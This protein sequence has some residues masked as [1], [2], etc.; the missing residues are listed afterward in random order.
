MYN[1]MGKSKIHRCHICGK[2][3]SQGSHLKRHMEIHD[4]IMRECRYCGRQY[5]GPTNLSRHEKVC[6]K[7]NVDESSTV[8][9][10]PVGEKIVVNVVNNNLIQPTQNT[11]MKKLT[12]QISQLVET[13]KILVT[14]MNELKNRQSDPITTTATNTTINGNVNTNISYYLNDTDIDIYEIKKKLIGKEAAYRYVMGLL[15][16]KSYEKFD[17]LL[18]KTIFEKPEN[19]PIR[20]VN[21][22]EPKIIIHDKLDSTI[23]DNGTRM[24]KTCSRIVGHSVSRAMSQHV[25][26][27]IQQNDED[28]QRR[29]MN[30]QQQDQIDKQLD[31]RIGL[32]YNGV[33]KEN[34]SGKLITLDR[35]VNQKHLREF[36]SHL[37]TIDIPI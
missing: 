14:D 36:L 24:N 16:A 21:L 12:D 30:E 22:K 7:R 17:W 20:V 25:G 27:I 9:A 28:I 11:E 2:Q 33:F 13:N 34:V 3:Y 35:P 18:D 31:D 5:T 19:I 4:G 6:R 32:L 15:D 8:D 26:A 37:S 23:Q 1:I 29:E 10:P